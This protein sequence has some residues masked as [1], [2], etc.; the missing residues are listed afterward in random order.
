VVSAGVG[1]RCCDRVLRRGGNSLGGYV[2]F[3]LAARGRAATVVAFAPAGGW[4]K[5]DQ[6]YE[7][8]LHAQRVLQEQMKAA[9][10]QAEGFVGT[11][12]GRRRAT[13]L[14]TTNFEHIPPDLLAHQM[15]SV[16]SCKS[17]V[18]LIENALRAGWTLDAENVT[19]PVRIVWGTAD[20][21]LP[22]PAAAARYRKDWLPQADWPA[23]P[24]PL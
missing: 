24:P 7:D 16:A 3:Q 11:P 5:G 18:P 6:S 1:R 13:Q 21:L 14:M 20:K 4:A 17:A 10:P 12:E 8:L 22:W 15:L 19:C 2:A 9:A 23:G